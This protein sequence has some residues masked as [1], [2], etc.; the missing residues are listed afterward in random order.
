MRDTGIAGHSHTVGDYAEL[1]A[2]E[3]G[4]PAEH[5]ERMRLAGMVH[6][7]GKTGVS[8]RLMSKPGPLEPDEWRSIRT[9]PEIG[10]RLLAHPE[11]EDL[12]AWVLAH[13]ERPDGKGYPFG[14]G[15]RHPDRGAHPGGRRRLRGDDLRAVLPLG[16]RRGDAAGELQAG[17][18][19]QFDTQVVAVFLAALG[20][21]DARAAAGVLGKPPAR[22]AP[23]TRAAQALAAVG[24]LAAVLSVAVVTVRSTA[25]ARSCRWSPP[26]SST[27]SRCCWSRATGASWLGLL[28]ALMSA[29]AWNFFHI[30]PTGGFTIAEGEHWVALGV[31]FIAAVAISALAGAARA[32]A[33]EAETRRRE[34][35]LDGRDGAPAARRGRY[36]TESLRAAGRAWR[37]RSA[38]R[39]WRSS[40]P[41]RTRTSAGARCRCWS[42]GSRVGTVMV[43]Q[44]HRPGRCSRRCRTEWCP[45]SRRS[46][47]PRASATSWRRR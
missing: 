3:L 26:A 45:R 47:P 18:G 41:G 28:T 23:L 22:A 27:C 13:H 25:C 1:M 37:P 7:I 46:W 6:D 39:R 31:F 24:L 33:E 4:F 2:R 38:S 30:P 17:A 44:R 34:A 19:T 15:R 32:R 29:A 11:F 5:V 42:T 12:R 21:E 20:A 14:L 36:S 35:D 16:A 9:H 40:W 43:P 10:A 8:D